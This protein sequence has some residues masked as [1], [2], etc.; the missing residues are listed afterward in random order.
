MYLSASDEINTDGPTLCHTST[1]SQFSDVQWIKLSW[2]CE[3]C[4][5]PSFNFHL[6]YNVQLLP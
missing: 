2:L 4:P 1:I 5:S 6:Y 3:G